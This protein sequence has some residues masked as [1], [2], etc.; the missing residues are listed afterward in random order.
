MDQLVLLL[1]IGAISLINWIIQK[2]A[3]H[4][5]KR[6]AEQARGDSIHPAAPPSQQHPET[7]FDPVDQTRKFL[8]ALGLPEDALPPKPTPASPPPLPIPQQELFTQPEPEQRNFLHKIRPDLEQRL[9]PEPASKTD[10]TPLPRLRPSE[11][12]AAKVTSS[13][14]SSARTLVT[15]LLAEE[16]GMRRAIVMKEILGSPKAFQNW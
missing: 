8:E 2:S 1:I 14:S 9:H 15:D 7:Q 5:E 10:F 3:E 6:K 16:D 4:R 12:G 13:P 11:L